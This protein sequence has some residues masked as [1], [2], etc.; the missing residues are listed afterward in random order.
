MGRALKVALACAALAAIAFVVGWH[1]WLGID[2]GAG[3]WVAGDARAT[4]AE[5]ARRV[6]W[7]TP[8]PFAPEL[9]NGGAVTRVALR[10]DGRC[11]VLATGERGRDASLWFVEL[12]GGRVTSE[13]PLLEL[14]APGD[15]V[16]PWFDGTVLVFA[17]DRDGGS[18]GL[19]LWTSRFDGEWF[20]SAERIAGDVNS[21]AD[22]TDPTLHDGELVFA[23]DRG[24]TGFDLYSARLDDSASTAA[25]AVLRLATL[26]EDAD[27]RDPAF[28]PDGGSLWYCAARGDS[29][30]LCRAFR[31]GT[32]W[33]AG[34][35]VEALSSAADERAPCPL[36]AGFELVFLRSTND[37]GSSSATA[38][39]AA[40][41]ELGLV[42]ALAWTLAEILLLTSLLALAAAAWFARDV[43]R[44]DTWIVALAISVLVHLLL[45]FLFGDV[46]M[47]GVS[48]SGAADDGGRAIRI[49][50]APAADSNG[51]GL[52]Q[53][54][55]G[56]LRR[57]DVESRITASELA[58]TTDLVALVGA[59]AEIA[60]APER[61]ASEA[62]AAHTE[63][64]VADVESAPIPTASAAR[65]PALP[66]D[67]VAVRRAD[68]RAYERGLVRHTVASSN[69]PSS[70][71]PASNLSASETA[72][73]GAALSVEAN[74][75]AAPTADR[76]PT[77]PPTLSATA[78]AS[79]RAL[80]DV[81]VAAP[82]APTPTSGA[83]SA[84]AALAPTAAT[85]AVAQ[86]ELVRFDTDPGPAAP[87]DEARMPTLLDAPLTARE[88]TPI[89]APREVATPY[90]SRTGPAKERALAENGG[91][92]ETEA[93]VANGL[94]Y[95][96]RIQGPLGSWGPLDVRDAKYG[97]VA[98]GKTAL[99]TLAFLA[100]GH[101]H[102][103]ATEHSGVVRRALAFLLATPH[104]ASAHF[105]DTSSYG[106]GIATFA[107][108]EALAITHDGAL[109]DSVQLAVAH[110]LERQSSDPDPRKFGG[111]PYY[112]ADPARSFDPWPRTSIT[113]W[114]VLALESA[115]LS[116]VSVPDV[117]FENAARFL[118]AARQPN[119]DWYRYAHDPTRL[120]SAYPTLPASTPAALF[121]L[122]CIGRDISGADSAG[123]RRYVL[124]RA[125]RG[126]RFTNE[127]DFVERGQGNPYFWYQGTLAMMR[128]GGSE[129][130]RWNV[131]LQATLLPAQ[132][133]DGSW[134]PI[135]AYAQYARD[136]D[137]D[138]AYTTA[139]CVLCLEAYYRYDLPLLRV[140]RSGTKAVDAAAR[141]ARPDRR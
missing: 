137:E 37:A 131:A 46:R 90:A 54:G 16:A 27:E 135:D 89:A 103:S 134:R 85:R 79:M 13:R 41:V 28:A 67:F 120:R 116:G 62:P 121:A 94:A 123:A 70:N 96:A 61:S 48:D 74:A 26:S 60:S 50:V 98:V 122:S 59:A 9:S 38:W 30:D 108:A 109:R 49:H 43:S 139:L 15:E 93:A 95:L 88:P 83:P 47:T 24:A 55:A 68:P 40:S 11:A 58:P 125:P 23:S 20:G 106:H 4:T 29:Y 31:A 138:R 19:D 118:D 101:T 52:T 71:L 45:F 75:L 10:R 63:R 104:R 105:G 34:E 1:T 117:A 76:S 12:D 130:R 25:S 7:R 127:R 126:Y 128:A 100:A 72:T 115:R 22:D 114:H 91:T 129:W 81:E 84:L 33:L 107:L 124:D 82:P 119:A 110:M 5:A 65:M 18:G 113:A 53:N 66:S 141:S 140:D 99:A 32:E 6:A 21:T 2:R 39:S 80:Q 64:A 44:Y 86:P 51:A 56:R 17:S 57:A 112:Y 102:T 92:R 78:G 3:S 87:R 73:T 8:Q 133:S 97:E 69:L 111:W 14:D 132:E 42:P 36:G 35:R 77:S 136:D